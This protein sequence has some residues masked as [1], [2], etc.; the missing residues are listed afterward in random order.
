MM[1]SSAASSVTLSWTE[2]RHAI[3]LVVIFSALCEV[4]QRHSLEPRYVSPHSLIQVQA[5]VV[6][7]PI[8]I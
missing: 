8:Q 4:L 3:M 2:M 7:F 5:E 6:P 1:G